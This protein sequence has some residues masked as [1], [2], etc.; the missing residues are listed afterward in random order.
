MAE[1]VPWARDQRINAPQHADLL[2]TTEFLAWN[3]THMFKTPARQVVLAGAT[4]RATR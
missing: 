4:P 1:S 3:T 2:P